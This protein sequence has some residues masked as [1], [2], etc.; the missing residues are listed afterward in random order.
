MSAPSFNLVKG[1]AFNLAKS[2]NLVSIGLGWDPLPGA[3]VDVDAHAFGVLAR[4]DGSPVFYNDASHA[5]SYANKPNLKVNP[6]KSFQT[7]DGSLHHSGDDRSGSSSAGGD[8]ETITV[9]LTKLPDEI[10]EVQF[11]LTI[12]EP[13]GATFGTVKNAFCRAINKDTGAELCKYALGTEFAT[14][15]SIQV[16]SLFKKDGNWSFVAIGAGVNVGLGD[17]LSKLS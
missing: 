8:D 10:T 3:N 13:N 14:A 1:S 12:Y 9:D 2:L 6:N 15:N 16:G 4:A 17:I 11:W 7:T 5:L